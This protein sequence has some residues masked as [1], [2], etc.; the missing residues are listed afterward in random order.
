MHFTVLYKT[1]AIYIVLGV[2][3]ATMAMTWLGH[4]AGI[5]LSKKSKI[6]KKDSGIISSGLFGL[7]AFLLGFTFSMSAARLEKS[8]SIIAEEANCIGTAI[9]RCDLYNEPDRSAMRQDFR[10]YLEARLDYFSHG[11]DPVYIDAANTAAKAAGNKIWARVTNLSHDPKMLVASNQMVVALNA[12]FDITVT[13]DVNSQSMVPDPIMWMLFI[14]TGFGGFLA[15]F[16]TDI[17]TLKSWIIMTL[18]A[19]LTSLVIYIIIDLDRPK[20]GLITTKASDKAMTDLRSL[21]SEK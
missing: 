6:D 12:M 16:T 7:L 13:R 10:D 1:E 5:Y 11:A 8:R 20:S 9:L 17:F 4:Y 15:G 3:L 14:L 21:L 19:F 18:N 2:F